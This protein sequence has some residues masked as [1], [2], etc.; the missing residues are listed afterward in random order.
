MSGFFS[1]ALYFLVLSILFRVCI[2]VL[3]RKSTLYNLGY[4]NDHILDT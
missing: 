3:L 2:T 1:P 4:T